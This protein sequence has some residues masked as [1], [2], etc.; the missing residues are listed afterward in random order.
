MSDVAAILQDLA[1]GRIDAAEAERR[2]EAV[3][4]PKTDPATPRAAETS[5]EWVTPSAETASQ[6]LAESESSWSTSETKTGQIDRLLVKAA[7]RRVK[8]IADPTV[9]AAMAEDVHQTKRRGSTLEISGEVELSGLGSAVNFVKSIRGVDDFKA[10]GIGQELDI[11]VNPQLIVNVE[12]TGGSLVTTGVT[13]LGQVRLTAG[14]ANLNGVEEVSDLVIQAG[15]ATVSGR[16]RDGWSR[17]RCESGQLTV[18]IAPDSDVTV[19]AE[20]RLGHV[21]WET[22][23]EHGDTELVVRSGR[24]RL[25]VAVVIGHASIRLGEDTAS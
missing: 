20:T 17:L 13:K 1:A 23:A 12:L 2:I 18:R 14:V 10:L 4:R 25:D 15:Q 3:G 9:K 16:F 24:A 22:P 5:A 8:I 19:K 21:S 11:R 7:G 6:P